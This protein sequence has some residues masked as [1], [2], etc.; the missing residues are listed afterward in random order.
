MVVVQALL[1]AGLAC[2]SRQVEEPLSEVATW[3][4]DYLRIDTTE[5][6]GNEDSAVEYLESLVAG[7]AIETRRLDVGDGRSSWLATL[8]ADDGT[9]TRTLLLL[10]H[11]DVV[12][13]GADWDVEPFAGIV[14]DGSIWGRGAIDSK[15]LGIAHLAALVALE[16]SG[17]PRHRGVAVLAT[18]GEE[19]G[20]E[21]GAER[22]LAKRPELFSE[23]AAVLNEG[24]VNRGFQGRLHWWGI[25]T[26]QKRP[27]WLRV[28]ADH[29]ESLIIALARLLE[30]PLEWQV[31]PTNRR[32]FAGL[33]PYYNDHWRAIFTELDRHIEPSGP[34]LSLLPGMASYFIDSLQ[35]NELERLPDGSARA[36]IDLRLLPE[37]DA[38]RKLE[39]VRS[40]LGPEAAVEI[41]LEAPPVAASPFDHEI[42]E[43]LREVLGGKAPVV[44]QTVSG[45]TDSRFFRRRELP[46][47]GFSPFILDSTVTATVHAANE[48]IPLEAFENGTELMRE[49]VESWV[50]R[51]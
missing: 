20:G 43:V 9:Q 50:A 51:H 12:P 11:T 2:D 36:S 21:I 35:I 4:Q 44:E 45:V 13:A 34:L 19:S 18:A 7:T 49:V 40:A 6:P 39:Q 32:V 31:T 1:L 25:E 3:L 14:R 16:R 41:L 22:W 28:T 8:P 23:V 17:S 38:A 26:S 29:S 37:S 33:A 30:Q 46:A 10:H 47:Y 27:L 42:V 15:G 48:R 5:P 24:G